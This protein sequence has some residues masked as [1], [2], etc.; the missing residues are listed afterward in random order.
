MEFRLRTPKNDTLIGFVALYSIE[1]NNQC[2]KTEIGIGDPN[3]RDKGYRIDALRLILRYGFFEL[4]LHRIRLDVVSYNT[5]AIRA[6]QEV[7]F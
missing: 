5:R 3:F 7:G 1:R 4:N 6:Y 2:G